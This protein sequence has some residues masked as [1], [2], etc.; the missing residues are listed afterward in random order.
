MSIIAENDRVLTS[1]IKASGNYPS[2]I[3]C[4]SGVLSQFI[5]VSINLCLLRNSFDLGSIRKSSQLVTIPPYIPKLLSNAIPQV[6][7]G[8]S[9]VD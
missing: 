9:E 5:Y 1:V 2:L 6:L 7:Y 3:V 4:L 8:M